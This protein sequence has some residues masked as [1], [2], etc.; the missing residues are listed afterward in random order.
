MKG[1]RV[2][3]FTL[4][5]V[6][7]A[8]AIAMASIGVLLA[9]FA[10]GLQRMSRAETHAQQLIVEKEVLSRLSQVNPA[11]SRSGSG[12]VGEWTFNWTARPLTGFKPVTDYFASDIPRSVAM[13][14]ISLEL[15]KTG[16]KQAVFEFKKLGW[17]P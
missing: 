12:E 16:D 1:S 7:V 2:D 15:Q 4:I 9:L 5:E 8:S 10:S 14:S 17:R 3:G 11:I 6:L 13:F